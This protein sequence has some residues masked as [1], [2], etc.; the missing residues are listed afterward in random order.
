MRYGWHASEQG[1]GHTDKKIS[2]DLM[3]TIV[4]AGY[5]RKTR[6][7][8][9]GVRNRGGRRYR[10]GVPVQPEDRIYGVL[11]AGTGARHHRRQRCIH[12]EA[13]SAWLCA[14]PAHLRVHTGGESGDISQ[15]SGIGIFISHSSFI[16]I[17]NQ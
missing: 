13:R 6:R 10:G 12:E 7:V 9:A 2:P 17:A 3:V 11:A 5:P 4:Y 16:C 15:P 1:I 14:Q 8:G